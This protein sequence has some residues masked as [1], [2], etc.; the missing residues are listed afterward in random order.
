MGFNSA[1]KGLNKNECENVSFRRYK[2][3]TTSVLW[4]CPKNGRGETAKSSYVMAST[5]KK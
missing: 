1:F 3:Q 2:N 4:T 5:R